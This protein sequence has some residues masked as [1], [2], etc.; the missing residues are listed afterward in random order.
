[1]KPPKTTAEGLEL[2][3]DDHA[4]LSCILHL[5]EGRAIGDVV[6]VHGAFSRQ[7]IFT[8]AG[9]LAEWF[10]LKGHRVLTFDLRGHGASGPGAGAR[11]WGYDDL[12]LRDLPAVTSSLRAR[13]AKGPL[14]VV[15]H[16]LGGHVALAAAIAGAIEVDGIVTV[17]TAMWGE[18]SS[19]P[20]ARRV[21]E[22]LVVRAF[23][24]ATERRGFF[25]ARALRLG[26]DDEAVGYV[27]DL[28]RM[29]RA[30]WRSR[31]GAHDYG[32]GRGALRI[33]VYAIASAGDR[34]FAPPS[35]VRAFHAPFP[36]HRVDVVERS[37]DGTAPP[38]HA[39]LVRSAKARAAFDR[40]LRFLRG[41]G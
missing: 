13:R 29:V 4:A 31:D 20:L 1:M 28:R 18:A 14:F 41:P 12:V 40:A 34:F 35:V 23:S 5:P 30:G 7:G 15:G 36:N 25:P 32:A 38:D 21:A 22:R 16:S 33:P 6:L 11:D 10:R 24:A 2:R 27:R 19:P 37:D 17:G 26:S 39:D 3:T 9:G 8:K